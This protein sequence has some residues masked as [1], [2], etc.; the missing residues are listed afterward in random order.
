MGISNRLRDLML[1]NLFVD[2]AAFPAGLWVSLHTADPA[3]SGAGEV[4]DYLRQ[5]VTFAPKEAGKVSNRGGLQYDN[6]PGCT[7]THFG[8]WDA[9]R[10]GAFL[11]GESLDMGLIVPKGRSLRWGPG[12]LVITIP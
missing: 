6:M 9:E 8:V 11:F 12:D 3:D 10:R 5:A 4:R 2:G 1:N 7:V